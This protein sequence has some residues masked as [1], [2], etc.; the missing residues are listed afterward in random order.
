[1]PITLL[2]EKERISRDIIM[3]AKVWIRGR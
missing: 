2:S 3:I 1:V